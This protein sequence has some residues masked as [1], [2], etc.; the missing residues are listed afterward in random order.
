[1]SIAFI[2]AGNMAGSL[3]N[4]LLESGTSPREIA[5]ADPMAI[6]LEKFAALGVVTANNNDQAVDGADVIVL[7]VKPQVTGAVLEAL[8]GLKPHQLIISIVAGIDLR[9]LETWLP[10]NQP[11][12]R[13]MPNTPALLGAG[14]TGLFANSRVSDQQ[15]ASATHI[16]EAV[17][18]VAWVNEEAHLDAVTAVSGSGPAYF[19]LLMENM[20]AAGQKL[21]LDAELSRKLTEQT[22]FGAALMA[23]KNDVDPGT[24]RKNVT[25]PG[26][27]TE[28]A[29]NLMLAQGLPATVIDALSAAENRAKELA[30]EFGAKS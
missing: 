22:A 23:Q 10:E 27:T 21:G 6:Q 8:S 30:V 11:I 18:E 15:K 14:M 13:C 12:V 19:F 17:G 2:G 9:S 1:V 5:A 4:G 7:A 29:L 16:L 3:I 25:S 28:A 24:L 20:I 26:G